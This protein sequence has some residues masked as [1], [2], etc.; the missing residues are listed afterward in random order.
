[1]NQ[2]ERNLD[3]HC[4]RERQEPAL[5]T[6]SGLTES[7]LYAINV[8]GKRYFNVL[9]LFLCQLVVALEI[10]VLALFERRIFG[11]AIV[12]FTKNCSSSFLT[13]KRLL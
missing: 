12:S 7:K 9:R 4:A 3:S 6:I 2:P 13:L 11:P 10:R 5:K 8:F 1:M